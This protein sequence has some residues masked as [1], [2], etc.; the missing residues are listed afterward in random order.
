MGYIV[1]ISK[2]NDSINWDVAAPQLDLAICRV[3]YGSKTVDRLYNQHV[4]NL[5]SRGVS[6]A[7]YA[8]GC[9]VSVADAIVEANDFL[10]R[11]SPNAKFLVLDVEDDTLKSMRNKNQLAEASQAFIDTCKAAGW[12]VGLYVAHHMYNQYNLRSVQADFVWL[13]RYGSNEGSP[14]VKPTYPCDMWQYTDNGYINGVGRVDINLLEGDK[15]LNWYIGDSQETIAPSS[16]DGI[17][18]VYIN[19]DNVN[20]RNGSGTEYRVIRKLRKGDSYKVWEREGD[21]LNLGGSQWV[22]YDSSYIHFEDTSIAGKRV[23]SKVSS[24]NYRNRPS[25]SAAHVVGTVNAGFGFTIDAK[26]VVD[27]LPQ[28]KVHNSKGETFYITASEGYVQV[29]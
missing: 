27:G 23:E 9:Y 7:A 8:Y 26:I 28:Y 14:Q 21:W 1:D 15:D 4:T 22:Y 16:N 29:K 13:P 19:G 5:E 11:V 25:W 20:L 24:L 12:K 18:I 17:G 3:Q 2:W 10:A 6:H